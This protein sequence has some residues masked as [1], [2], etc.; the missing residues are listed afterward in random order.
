MTFDDQQ[1][2][3]PTLPLGPMID[4][5][6]LLLCF[7]LVTTDFTPL[8]G[9]LEAQLPKGLGQEAATKVP[10]KQD[11]MRI[12]IVQAG[13]DPAYLWNDVPVEGTEQQALA[14]IRRRLGEY[15]E[16]VQSPVVVIDA[17]GDVV[18]QAVVNVRSI[19]NELDIRVMI[20]S[21]V[22]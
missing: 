12:N 5:V 1:D 11:E 14:E 21:Q 18:L 16:R 7:F 2:E 19:C 10:D 20:P 4:A 8:E 22:S 13:K 17:A 9:L 3:H 15:K 6:F